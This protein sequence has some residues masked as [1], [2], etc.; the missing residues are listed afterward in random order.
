[1]SDSENKIVYL[2]RKE[3]ISCC[4]RLN[5]IFYTEQ[6]NREIYG[7]CNNFHGHGHNYTV[8]VTCKGYIN[9]ENGMV[10]N[11]SDLKL[12]M[13]KV[14]D[15]LDHKNLDKD[16][17]YFMNIISTTENLAVYIYDEL[18]K[19]MNKPWLLYEVK[20]KETDKNSV[21][22]R[23]EKSEQTHSNFSEKYYCQKQK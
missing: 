8:K 1:M 14:L 20:I 15:Q 2:T 13:S 9:S 21:F 5:S 4:H 17:P 23:G 16:V 11:I 12:Y 3:V 6:K 7:K 10:M 19:Q 22:Y 18:K